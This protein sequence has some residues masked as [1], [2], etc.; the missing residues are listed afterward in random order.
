[1]GALT[2]E[3]STGMIFFTKNDH[4]FG[5]KTLEENP[6]SS[7]QLHVTYDLGRGV[8]AALSGT[9]DY[10]GRST[11]GSVRSNDLENNLRMGVTLALPVSRRNSIKVFAST[12]IYTSSGTDVTLVG[13]AWQYRWG[14]GL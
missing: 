13:I 3:L 12:G 14:H 10:G 6:V 2:V 4:Y 1:M 8:W 9:Y 7:T 11:I 5:G